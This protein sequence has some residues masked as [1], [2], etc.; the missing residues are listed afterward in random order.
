MLSRDYHRVLQLGQR[1]RPH[2][3]AWDF[4]LLYGAGIVWNEEPLVPEFWMHQLSLKD[5]PE[6]DATV[7]KHPLARRLRS[8]TEQLELPT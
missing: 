7:L 1:P 8:D 6:L 4:F 3:I 5:V 2:H